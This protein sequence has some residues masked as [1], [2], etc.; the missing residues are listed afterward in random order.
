MHEIGF[1]K[2]GIVFAENELEGADV[3][4]IGDEELEEL[5]ILDPEVSALTAHHFAVLGARCKR[6][7]ARMRM[8][9]GTTPRAF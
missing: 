3:V 1:A 6:T 9:H 7:H 8:S 4:V 2:E 5:G